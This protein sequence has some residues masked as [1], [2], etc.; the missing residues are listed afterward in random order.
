MGGLITN[1]V[2]PSLL[3]SLAFKTVGLLSRAHARRHSI[4]PL[5]DCL[6]YLPEGRIRIASDR[7]KSGWNSSITVG[8]NGQW[9][10]V[11]RDEIAAPPRPY[12]YIL[13]PVSQGKVL[14]G[15]QE[16]DAASALNSGK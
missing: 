9:F 3:V 2:V 8:L 14:R 16:Y 1:E 5:A 12:V 13:R 6:N 10:E 11:E 15:Y 4:P 7:A